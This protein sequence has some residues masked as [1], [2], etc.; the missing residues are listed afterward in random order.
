MSVGVKK[1]VEERREERGSDGAGRFEKRR[2]ALKNDDAALAR[3]GAGAGGGA[4]PEWLLSANQTHRPG[5]VA[6]SP[7]KNGDRRGRDGALPII[8]CRFLLRP[9]PFLQRR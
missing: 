4:K 6:R 7:I 1:G 3:A 2:V 8:H 9:S 5:V